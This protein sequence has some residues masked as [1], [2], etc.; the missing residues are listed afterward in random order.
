MRIEAELEQLGRRIADAE[1]ANAAVEL[2]SE[3]LRRADET[4]RARFSPQITAE[5]GHIL[6]EL[7]EN[8]YPRVLLEPDMHLSVREA[9]GPGHASRRRHEL[10]PRRIRCILRCGWPCA[11]VCCRRMRR[12]CSTTRS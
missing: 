4:L 5:A 2:A 8:K 10:R 6:A 7:T 3:A 9:D 11:A 12:W 1:E